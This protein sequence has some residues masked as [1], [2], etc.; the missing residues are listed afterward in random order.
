MLTLPSGE[1]IT[2]ADCS[3]PLK[4][5]SDLCVCDDNSDYPNW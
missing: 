1:C 4:I 2:D 3:D 5:D